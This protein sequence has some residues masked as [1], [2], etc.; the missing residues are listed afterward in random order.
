MARDMKDML[1]IACNPPALL[2]QRRPRFAVV[3]GSGLGWSGVG[4]VGVGWGGVGWGGL[5]WGG[6]GWGVAA[7]ECITV[8]SLQAKQPWKTRVRLPLQS[9]CSR[10]TVCTSHRVASGG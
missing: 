3:S 10:F 6:V 1:A 7:V 2:L 5:G 8:T 9:F 4:W